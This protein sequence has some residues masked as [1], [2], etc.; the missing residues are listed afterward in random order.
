MSAELKLSLM[1]YEED[2][3][4]KGQGIP[5]GDFVAIKK[6]KAFGENV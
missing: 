6:K 1:V 5:G 2:K 4:A 3:T